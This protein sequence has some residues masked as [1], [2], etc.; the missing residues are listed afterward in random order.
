MDITF[1]N[2]SIIIFSYWTECWVYIFRFLD[3]FKHKRRGS[4]LG[5]LWVYGIVVLIAI[6]IIASYRFTRLKFVDIGEGLTD[7]F[8]SRYFQ[9]R[10]YYLLDSNSNVSNR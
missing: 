9:N 5:I 3:T 2:Y 8:L 7:N 6:P 1:Y 10:C 4:F